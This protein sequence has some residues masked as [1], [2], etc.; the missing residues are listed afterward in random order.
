M[1]RLLF[2]G[3]WTVNG[4]ILQLALWQPHFEPVFTKLSTAALWVQLH[5]LPVEFGD[6]ESLETISSFFGR[7]LNID[8]FTSLLSR[9]K[10]TRLCVEIDLAKPLK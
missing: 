2:D 6:G 10:Y 4:I 3:P 1:Q 9:S 5:N 7:L 8:E